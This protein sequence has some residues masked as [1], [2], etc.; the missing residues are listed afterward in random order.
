MVFLFKN[1]H[2]P[3]PYCKPEFLASA[4]LHFTNLK[5]APGNLYI[6]YI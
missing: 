3:A 4:G 6:H 1:W 2:L 5:N